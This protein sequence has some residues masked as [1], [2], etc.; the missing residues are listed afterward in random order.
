MFSISFFAI[1]ESDREVE[2]GDNTEEARFWVREGKSYF[3]NLKFLRQNPTG[4]TTELVPRTSLAVTW[5]L[6]PPASHWRPAVA[7]KF[8]RRYFGYIS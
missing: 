7:S 3:K 6:T 2:F 8:N 1:Y 5:Q 4:M